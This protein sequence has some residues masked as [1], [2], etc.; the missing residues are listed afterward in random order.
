[1]TLSSPEMEKQASINSPDYAD[2]LNP[3]KLVNAT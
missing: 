1:M 2:Q 3:K